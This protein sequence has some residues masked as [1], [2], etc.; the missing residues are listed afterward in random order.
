MEVGAWKFE[1]VGIA[2]EECD[3]R[4]GRRGV[5]SDSG[6]NDRN[7]KCHHDKARRSEY[8]DRR[9]ECFQIFLETLAKKYYKDLILL[10]VD[11]AGNHC[12]D[13]L[14]IPTNIILISFDLTRRS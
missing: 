3:G 10:F 13:E 4:L 2:S 8:S 1:I 14:E 7:C 6:G 12:S 9:R 11:V 5:G